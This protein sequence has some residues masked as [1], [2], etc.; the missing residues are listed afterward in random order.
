L[1]SLRSFPTRRSSDL[2]HLDGLRLDAV[3]AIEDDSPHHI[4]HE[5]AEAVHAGPGR[6]RQVHLILENDKNGARHLQRGEKGEVSLYSA[7][8]SEEHMSELQSRENL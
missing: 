2:Y 5:L 1:S 3:H 4:L 6:E 8:R 7:Q